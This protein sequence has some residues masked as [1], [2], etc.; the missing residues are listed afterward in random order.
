VGEVT[1]MLSD[2][3]LAQVRFL[4]WLSVSVVIDDDL[5]KDLPRII[6]IMAKYA[7]LPA[8]LADA[9]LI[10]L[11]ERRNIATVASIDRDF[12]VY[13][14]PRGRTLVNAFTAQ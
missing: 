3:P 1:A 6:D 2:R 4:E 11:C 13:R 9:S 8:D 7:D 5:L 14:P 10:A 12:D